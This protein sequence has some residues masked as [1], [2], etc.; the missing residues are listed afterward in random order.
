[1]SFNVKPGSLSEQQLKEECQNR[2]RGGLNFGHD[3]LEM[4]PDQTGKEIQKVFEY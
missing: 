2:S 1:M 4:L 3:E